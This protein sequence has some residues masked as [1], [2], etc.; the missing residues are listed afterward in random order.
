MPNSDDTESG[1]R[2][3]RR[4][5]LG[6]LG[7]S[8]TAAVAGCLGED[9]AAADADES[10]ESTGSE[11][12]VSSERTSSDKAQAA[13]ERSVNNPLPE[14][15]SLRQEAYVQMEEAVR[16]SAIMIP[17]YHNLNERFW[18]D[19]VDVPLTGAL[20]AHW[21]QHN[22]TTVEGQNE[23]NLVNST[24]AELD[25]IMS[26]DTASSAVITQIY[27]NLTAF[28]NGVPELENQLLD[29]FEVSDDGTRWTFTIRDDVTFHD[30]SDVTA[31]DVVYSWR[32]TVES[33]NSERRSFTLDQPVG[34]GIDVEFDDNGDP[35]EDTLAVEAIDDRTV[36]IQLVGP[37]PDVL[38]VIAYSSFAV[39]P[40]GYVGDIAGYE[41]EVTHQ[42]F[43][44]AVANGTGP[45]ELDVFNID[46]D[47]RVVRNPDY[48][49]DVADVTAVN[50]EIIEDDQAAW[51][52][53]LE[54][55]ADI[56][57]V[58]TFAY[59]P[60]AIDAE[61]DDRNRQ[62]GK[63]GPA[64]ELNEE[65]NYV[66]VSEL[67]T[68]YFGFNATNVPKPVRQAV[69]YVLNKQQ[70]V[71]DVF[72]GRGTPAYSYLP[73]GMWPTGADGYDSFVDEYPFSRG[74]SDLQSARDVLAEGG[75]TPDDPAEVTLTTYVSQV[76]ETAAELIRDLLAGS[77]VEV[78]IDQSEFSVLLNRGED[79]DLGMYTLGWIWSW[80]AAP[81]GMFQLEPKNTNTSRMPGETDGFYFDW[82]TELEEE[83]DG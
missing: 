32:R 34:L 9:D 1:D 3:S 28:P 60:D 7:G 48:Y 40:E 66:S 15:E 81:Y 45:F 54:Q 58:P 68:Y 18:Y 82:Q 6:L 70:I 72:A 16:D 11:N 52:Y 20:G 44:T 27:E 51:T 71:E 13:W 73:P 46:E 19:Y 31:A 79:G 78:T 2:P 12:D 33:A 59:E 21:Q 30:G 35:V 62:V 65:V 17:L 14:D 64:G 61:S 29:G 38:D 83:Q 23:L 24:F 22:T 56:F 57:G 77:G 25:P 76:F 41:G 47:V 36:E 10:T 50:W 69:A 8:A 5:M 80:P 49:G 55:N 42:E 75:F 43:S 74:D 4:Q 53:A 39:I 37:N 26:T 63:Y 67:S